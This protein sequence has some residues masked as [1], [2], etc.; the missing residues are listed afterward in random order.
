MKP[1]VRI[2]SID[3]GG[4]RGLIPALVLAEIEKRTQKPIFQLFDLIAGTS[5]GAILTLAL[6]KPDRNGKPAY[7]ARDIVTLYEKQGAAIFSRSWWR[8]FPLRYLFEEKYS[9]KPIEAV[10]NDYFSDSRLRDALTPVVITAYEIEQ[11]FPFLF[12]SRRAKQDPTYDFPMKAVARSSSAAPT[13][14]APFALD[15]QE[16]VGHYALIDGGVYANNPTMCGF[17]EA[18]ITHPLAEDFL[19]V[20]LGTGEFT[21]RLPLEKARKW[22]L[23]SWAQPLLDIVF[24]GVSAVTDFQMQ[25]LLPPKDQIKRYYRFQTRLDPRS[26]DLDNPSRENL[27]VLKI[28][29]ESLIREQTDLIDILS[30][31][32]VSSRG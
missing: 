24:H 21:R 3:G 25:Q 23:I 9:A 2:L 12:K 13:Y 6:V 29:A 19:V 4:I 16:S 22:G 5:T 31:Q 18:K 14:F 27:R 1:A 30:R 17:V 32:L 8:R 26:N 20:S 7:S 28:L 10:L 11:Q 15:S